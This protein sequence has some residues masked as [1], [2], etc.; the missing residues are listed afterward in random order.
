MNYKK[1]LLELSSTE[2]FSN[3]TRIQMKIDCDYWID[4]D[5]NNDIIDYYDYQTMYN[6]N[7]NDNDD[8]NSFLGN[9]EILNHLI[10]IS[11]FLNNKNLM[12]EYTYLS[13]DFEFILNKEFAEMKA[14]INSV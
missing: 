2:Q 12:N 4:D 3:D 7:N 9:H 8:N 6:D 14:N 13:Y 10:C 5:Y 11:K 1:K